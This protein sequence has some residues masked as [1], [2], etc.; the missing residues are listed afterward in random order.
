MTPE[1]KIADLERQLQLQTE[2]A[3][4][5]VANCGVIERARAA[6]M[7]QLDEAKLQLVHYVQSIDAA[8]AD[9]N[10]SPS[11]RAE[12]LA[13]RKMYPN[14]AKILPNPEFEPVAWRARGEGATFVMFVPSGMSPWK[15]GEN[16]PNMLFRAPRPFIK[17]QEWIAD[18]VRHLIWLDTHEAKALVDRL[19]QLHY[20][21][22]EG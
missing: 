22:Q 5:A 2:R 4:T 12:F 3:E 17:L 15:I 11:T 13:V 19:D 21:S 1:E 7:Q 18:A 9:E 16:L 8:L 6:H 10:L 14:A 20:N